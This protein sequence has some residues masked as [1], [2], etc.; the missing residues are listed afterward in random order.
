[1]PDCIVENEEIFYHH[2]IVF[3]VKNNYQIVFNTTQKGIAWV[4]IDGKVY[5][6]SICGVVRSERTTHRIEIQQSVLDK[7]G[8]Y[9]IGYAYIEDRVPYFPKSGEHITKKYKFRPYNPLDGGQIYV[10]ADAHSHS[11]APSRAASFFG[12]KLDLLILNGDIGNKLIDISN[13]MTIYKIADSVC[14]GEIPVIYTRGNHETRGIYAE[15]LP[16]YIGNENGNTYFSFRIGNVWGVVLDCGEDKFD[17]HPEYGEIADYR[18]FREAQTEYLKS[19]IKNAKNE[20][21]ADGVEYKIAVCHVPF[22]QLVHDFADDI[23]DAWTKLLNE[24]G[25]DMM[26]TG[27]RHKII[28]KEANIGVANKEIPNFPVVV[29]ARMN[30][31]PF[32]DQKNN[33]EE[34][35]ATAVILSD[36]KITIKFT[37]S[38]LQTVDEHIISK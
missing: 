30:D 37:N 3:V 24:I 26:L 12:D 4:E 33:N 22:T 8:E 10:L 19:I 34:F 35:C 5:K 27:H 29:G 20:Y 1:M 13:L 31:D 14:K 11:T 21:E 9:T 32:I 28:F 7:V 18:R 23:Y 17:E 38:L 2:P 36:K 16:E 25:V 6:D 15:S